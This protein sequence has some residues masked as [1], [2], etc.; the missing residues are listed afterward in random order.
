MVGETI[1]EETKQNGARDTAG[2][3]GTQV[4]VVVRQ[5]WTACV[6]REMVIVQSFVDSLHRLRAIECDATPGRA[7]ELD[8]LED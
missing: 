1:A 7:R 4:G 6:C 2:V 5:C 3:Q 8:P